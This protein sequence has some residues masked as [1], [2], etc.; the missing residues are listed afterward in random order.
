[1]DVYGASRSDCANVQLWAGNGTNAQ[2]WRVMH[3]ANGYVILTSVNSGKV[4]DV[5]G[6]SDAN[7]ANVQQYTSN[8]TYAE[9][10]SDNQ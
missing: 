6:G 8:G 5:Y 4:L 2:K 9:R 3:D 7:G 10:R 1:M